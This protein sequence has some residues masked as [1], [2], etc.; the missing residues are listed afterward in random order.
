MPAS[1]KTKGSIIRAKNLTAEENQQLQMFSLR[2]LA[3]AGTG[4]MTKCARK[5]F[6]LIMLCYPPD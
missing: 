6:N 3:F 5:G 4:A 1:S 2:S